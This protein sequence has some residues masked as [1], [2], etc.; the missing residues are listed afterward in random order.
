MTFSRKSFTWSL[1]FTCNLIQN[2]CILWYSNAFAL[3]YLMPRA[4]QEQQCPVKWTQQP[5]KK[6]TVRI[7][8]G[9]IAGDALA[10][11]MALISYQNNTNVVYTGVLVAPTVVL[12]VAYGINTS[13]QVLLHDASTNMQTVPI[14]IS[15]IQ[16]H[17]RFNPESSTSLIFYNIAY[18]V[19]ESSAP[20]ASRPVA[21]VSDPKHPETGS[22]VRHVGYGFQSPP[23]QPSTDTEDSSVLLRQVDAPVLQHSDC[24]QRF[25]RYVDSQTQAEEK[26]YCSGYDDRPC[27]PW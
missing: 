16:Q 24:V 3:P 10:S 14:R 21:V 9:Q 6:S 22:F 12:T 27:V 15:S 19:L 11:S 2:S 23:N 25:P 5:P 13:W 17:P 4:A 20:S 8:G 26:V 1:F 18:I 7:V